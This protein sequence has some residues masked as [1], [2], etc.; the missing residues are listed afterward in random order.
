MK[1]FFLSLSAIAL[2]ATVPVLASSPV[3]ASIRE[4]GTKIAQF[5][6][7]PEVKLNLA[8]AKRMVKVDDSG[9]EQVNWE[10]IAQEA[11]VV[12]GDVL[13]YTV[14]G[15]NAG[16]ATANNFVITQPIPTQTMYVLDSAASSNSATVTYSIDNGTTFSAEP[17][18]QV[19]DNG[20]L[21]EQPA[22][23]E[24][25]THVRWSFEQSLVAQEEV[26]ASYEVTIK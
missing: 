2:V 24:S 11:T 20:T 9:N 23:P 4:A 5:L 14:T 8:A 19:D 6:A 7:R 18:I 10:D 15:E 25:Y 3:Q 17:T 21:I 22:P 12:P 1:R 26:Q 16:D 13:R